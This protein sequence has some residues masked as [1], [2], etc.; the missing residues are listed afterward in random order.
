LIPE[1]QKVF[2]SPSPRTYSILE[3][4]WLVDEKVWSALATSALQNQFLPNTESSERVEWFD[5]W[6]NRGPQRGMSIT[7]EFYVR[8]A[9]AALGVQRKTDPASLAVEALLRFDDSK[10]IA[11]DR[12]RKVIDMLIRLN[13]EPEGGRSA[14]H[15]LPTVLAQAL[16]LDPTLFEQEFIRATVD[17]DVCEPFGSVSSEIVKAFLAGEP[18]LSPGELIAMFHWMASCPSDLDNEQHKVM[19]QVRF[20][21]NTLGALEAVTEIGKWTQAL[22]PPPPTAS[23]EK[24]SPEEPLKGSEDDKS[25]LPDIAELKPTW[26]SPWFSHRE[27]E[28]LVAYLEAGGES[29]WEDVC[30][31]VAKQVASPSVFPYHVGIIAEA[32]PALRSDLPVAEVFE[33]AMEHL[34]EKLL[35]QPEPAGRRGPSPQV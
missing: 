30:K 3:A 4:T 18:D 16:R 12:T 25:S 33:V 28:A 29:A 21:L 15:H 34:G 31:R 32:L 7:P 9:T 10:T 5:Y 20:Q 22:C 35:F 26:F 1:A 19:Q 14:V 6:M 17:H 23:S 27:H 11:A 13:A 2:L 8:S 24:S